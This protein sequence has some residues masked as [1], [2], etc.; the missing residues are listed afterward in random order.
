MLKILWESSGNVLVSTH[1]PPTYWFPVLIATYPLV[2]PVTC[3]HL[4]QG[5]NV[6][7]TAITIGC[8]VEA[9]VINKQGEE[10]W[11]LV[12]D[13]SFLFAPECFTNFPQRSVTLQRV[14][15]PQTCAFCGRTSHPSYLFGCFPR[16]LFG[17]F[18]RWVM[19]DSGKSLP[20]NDHVTFEL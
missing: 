3:C 6:K 8:V 18:P 5:H 13:R 1:V 14:L 2:L 16:Y 19:A 4:R 11:Q 10:A 7:P 17:C 12:Q 20:N 15:Q 9:L